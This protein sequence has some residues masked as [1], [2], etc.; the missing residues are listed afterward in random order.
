MNDDTLS[1]VPVMQE[2]QQRTDERERRRQQ[3]D[4]RLDE[5]LELQH[6]HGDH[7]RRGQTEHEQQRAEGLLLARVLAAEL[8]ADAGGR[9]VLREHLPDVAHHGA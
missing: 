7:A 2:Q 1:G 4:E 5:R 8:H 6:H 3:D 9:R